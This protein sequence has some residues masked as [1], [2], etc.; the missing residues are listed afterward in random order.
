MPTPPPADTIELSAGTGTATLAL[1]GAEPLSWRV[2]GREL[3]WHGDP[4]HWAFRAPILFPVVGSSSEGAIRVDGQ[5][6]PMAQHGFARNLPFSLVSAGPDRAHLRLTADDET[7][8]RYPFAFALDVEAV[9]APD[10]LQLA[11]TVTNQGAGDMPFAI[12]FHP[13]FPW[14]FADGARAEH[15]VV[16]SEAESPSIPGV[17][18]K[19]L[20]T[21]AGREAPLAGRDLPLDP[22]MFTEALVFLD[23]RSRSMAFTA[24]SGAAIVMETDGF[25][26]LAVWSRPTA[27]FLSLEAWT[28]HA[29]W[30]GFTGELKERA[31]MRV[32]AAG[33]SH[34]QAVTLRWRDA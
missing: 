2:G 4:E 6:Y 13:A 10:A 25:P 28:G 29:D 32:L 8:A 5:A 12:G 34:R 23:A 19:A 18:D 7:R 9:L 26:H 33:E 11:F 14:P 27:P 30:D 16:F 15:R 22:A 17:T 21:P 3:L 31:S 1:R 20:L 24:P